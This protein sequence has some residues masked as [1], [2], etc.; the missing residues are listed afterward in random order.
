[1]KIDKISKRMIAE[2]EL[3]LALAA[4]S[5]LAAF[6]DI[7]DFGHDIYSGYLKYIIIF[8]ALSIIFG[9]TEMSIFCSIISENLNFIERFIACLCNGIGMF[10]YIIIFLS[11]YGENIFYGISTVCLSLCFCT[12]LYNIIYRSGR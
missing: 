12:I 2:A 7:K 5:G 4:V 1:M 6:Y 3:I 10:I 11:V 8:T 9:F